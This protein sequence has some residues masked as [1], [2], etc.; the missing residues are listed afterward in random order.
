MNI[1]RRN[2]APRPLLWARKGALRARGRELR[3]VPV[4]PEEV[5]SPAAAS[6]GDPAALLTDAV[7]LGVITSAAAEL[8][9]ATRLDGVPVATYA[10]ARGISAAT[11]YKQR[12]RAEARLVAAIANGQVSAISDDGLPNV[13]P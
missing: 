1:D 2:I 13:E 7:R 6:A 8:I 9:K 4:D 3:H 12:E 5:A 10:G 11:A